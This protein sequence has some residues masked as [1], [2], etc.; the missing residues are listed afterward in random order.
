MEPGAWSLLPIAITLAVAL[1]LRNVLLGL[2]AGVLAGAL[3][4]VDASVLQFLPRTIRDLIVPEVADSY[5]ASVL[6]LLAFIGGFVKLIEWSGAGL[7]F[8]AAATRFVAGRVSAQLGAWFGG[9]LIFFSDLG[10]PLIVGPTFQ[11]LFDR[12]GLSRQKLAFVLD[13]TSS[14]VAILI[15]FIGWGVFIMSVLA[16][17]FAANGVDL[18]EWDAFVAAIPYQFYA[19]LAIAIVPLVAFLNVDIGPMRQAEQHAALRDDV[20]APDQASDSR[21]RASMVWL[22]LAVLAASLFLTLGELGFPFEPVAG[23]EFRAG[24]AA[25]YWFAAVALVVLILK[26]RVASFA[27]TSSTYVRG[28]A[29]M[30]PI[31]ATLVLAWTLGAIG[32]QLGSGDYVARVAGENVAGWLL[33]ATVFLL[34]AIISFATGSSWG[35]IVIMMPLAVPAAL[36]TDAALPVAIGAVLSGGLFGDHSSPVSETT[37]LSSTGAGTSPLEHFTTQLPYAL[38]NGGIALIAFLVAGLVAVPAIAVAAVVVQ[39]VV[40]V[41]LRASSGRTAVS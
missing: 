26:A 3:M 38:V 30:L 29:G 36:A 5:N 39:A 32:E 1:S 11:T 40:M 9:I 13:S 17:A 27:D 7:A 14:P 19:W 16:D 41:G 18:S 15:P 34:A 12:L 6:V 25:A 37:I 10:T 28:M 8:A 22:P 20:Q 31:A 4:I 24:L 23:S 35:T 2:F 33:P 21:A